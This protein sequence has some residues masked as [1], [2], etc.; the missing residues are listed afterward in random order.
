MQILQ[1]PPSTHR[2]R[3][4]YA[5]PEE[6]ARAAGSKDEAGSLLQKLQAICLAQLSTAARMAG[7]CAAMAGR[8]SPTEALA[9]ACLLRT[10]AALLGSRELLGKHAEVVN[11]LGQH[12]SVASAL[13]QVCTASPVGQVVLQRPLLASQMPPGHTGD[14]SAEWT[15]S[16]VQGLAAAALPEEANLL[17]AFAYLRAAGHALPAAARAGLPGGLYCRM[18]A[19]HLHLLARLLPAPPVRVVICL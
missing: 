17:D 11:R 2:S 15:A 3:V 18:L 10:A 5:G 8:R 16:V 7:T 9:L 14:L 12:Q 1:M 19:L 6:P 4:R 13:L